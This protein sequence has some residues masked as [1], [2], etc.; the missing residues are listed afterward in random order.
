MSHKLP[1]LDRGHHIKAF[2][3][4]SDP[5]IKPELWSFAHSNKWAINP[6]KLVAFSQQKMIPDAAR[7]YPQH[8]IEE[9]MPQ[10]LKQYMETKLFPGICLKV[11]KGSSLW[12]TRK[13]STVTQKTISMFGQFDLCIE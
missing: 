5:A 12:N 3:L 8:I 11:K 6:L 4:L 9:E 7:K 1:V 13:P 2:L 10:S